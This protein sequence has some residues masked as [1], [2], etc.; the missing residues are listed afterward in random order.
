MAERQQYEGLSDSLRGASGVAGPRG[1]DCPGPG[2]TGAT[3]QDC[4]EQSKGPL[5]KPGSMIRP[6][7]QLL[8]NRGGVT[9]GEVKE[10]ACNSWEW[11]ALVPRLDDEAFLAQM[12]HVLK[13]C[14]FDK[15]RPA[16]S[17]N[18]ELYLVHAPEAMKRLRDLVNIE[19]EMNTELDIVEARLAVA[20]LAF[21][22]RRATSH[23]TS[24]PVGFTSTPHRAD[25]KTLSMA[26]KII[27]SERLKIRVPVKKTVDGNLVL[28]EVVV[29][30]PSATASAFEVCKVND[31]RTVMV[32]G[33]SGR[34]F[35]P[36][37]MTLIV[38]DPALCP[39]CETMA[40]M[41]WRRD[42]VYVGCPACWGRELAAMVEGEVAKG[43]GW[44]SG[45]HIDSTSHD[46]ESI[47]RDIESMNPDKVRELQART[48]TLG[49]RCGELEAKC[50]ELE[51]ENEGLRRL[52]NQ[53]SGQGGA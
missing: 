15:R 33:P 35:V 20:R 52:L 39:K 21:E 29:D 47:M 36:A 41:E 46:V 1:T 16:R 34:H 23:M 11:E 48:A 45:Y 51:T 40:R 32:N 10:L 19:R 50:R 37:G 9:R 44:T 42:G 30:L 4:G 31:D 8:I 25:G 13:N 5:G 26:F 6:E 53:T 14:E 17:Y 38:K 27:P 49:D 43:V 2:P 22:K 28:S 12:D 3:G 7:I 18:E 24:H